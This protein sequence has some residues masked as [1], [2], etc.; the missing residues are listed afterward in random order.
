MA[1]PSAPRWEPGVLPYFEA[2]VAVY[3]M[4]A[5]MVAK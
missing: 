3:S 5:R 1:I 2:I 4:K